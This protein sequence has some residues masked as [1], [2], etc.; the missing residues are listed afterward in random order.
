M[1]NRM[2]HHSL[3]SEQDIHL[4]KEGRHY[5]LY[6]KLGSREIEVDG[7]KGVYF[8]VWAPNAKSVRVIGNFNFWNKDEC[9]MYPRWDHS[10]IW[11][12]FVPNIAAEEFYKFGIETPSGDFLEKCDLMAFAWE[13]P[14]QTA[15]QVKNI[16]YSW[17]DEKWMKKRKK[18]N[19]LDAP[20][21]VYE[22]HMGSWKRQGADGKDFLT[23]Q[24]MIKEMVPYIKDMGY[25]HV[26]FL[27]VME[28]PFDGSWGYQSLGYFAPTSR[29][30]SPQDFMALVDA[31]HQND[32][33]VILDWVPSHFPGDAHGIKEY[34]GTALY[35]HADPQQGYHPDWS[36][37]I[38]N[39]GRNEVRAFLISS[40]IFWLEKYHID[41]IRVDAVASMLYRDY[42][43]KEGE[44]Q[45]NQYGGRE[46][47]EAIQFL[48]EL[49]E[50]VYRSFPDVQTIAEESTS[51]PM[52]SKPTFLG[53][54]GFGQKWMMGWMND[55][56]E[57]FKR[58]SVYRKY[59]HNEISFSL[60]YAFS[61]NF[62]LPLSHDECVHGKGS[63]IDR[64]PGDTWQKFANTR[65]L[66]AYMYTH[67]GTK[68]NFMGNEFAQWDEWSHQKSLDWHL[69]DFEPHKG[70]QQMVKDLN[71]LYSKEKALHEIAFG[72]EGFEWIDYNDSE[73][74]TL[75]YL[76]KSAKESVLVVL[77]FT[78]SVHEKYRIGVP[79]SKSV[80]EI[81]NTDLKKYGGSDVKNAGVI[82]LENVPSHSRDHSITITLPP[83]G[84]CVF[85]ETN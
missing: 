25:T 67:P 81:F 52:V 71:K 21:S 50:E 58:D 34:D 54:L 15:T 13:T 77:N 56:L 30:G 37:Y 72:G 10:G 59:H 60:T 22:V 74:T 39:Y 43:R 24:D 57:F 4:F 79:F 80:K 8:A 14:P 64:M 63:I 5:R 83:L 69:T 29:F 76:R 9:L 48:K 12:G 44:W 7:K 78:P 26:E 20:Y 31:F 32:I 28:H 3:F 27:P 2:V 46:N 18:N 84:V 55:T 38:F 19:A 47:L 62:M 42:S 51:F 40:A 33:G 36:S 6:E 65:L 16:D 85:K 1:K 75:S 41:G 68:L 53:G 23:Y 45:P 82:S 35:E 61:E 11:E 70:V 66:Y 17:K 73:N 49:N